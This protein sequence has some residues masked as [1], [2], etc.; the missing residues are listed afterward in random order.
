LLRLHRLE[1]LPRLAQALDAVLVV[2][3]GVGDVRVELLA[4]VLLH[5]PALVVGQLLEVHVERVGPE[6]VV[7]REALLVP[8]LEV[9]DPALHGLPK[10]HDALLALGLV[11][12]DRLVDLL[13]ELAEVLLAG[14]V[15]DPRDAGRREVE[16]LL[17]LLRRHVEQV[18]DPARHALEEPDVRDGGGQVHVAHALTADLRARDLHAAALADDALVADC[19]VLAAVALPVLRGT[20]DALAEEPVLLGLQR[21]VVDCL[22]L[23][24]LAARPR[25]DLRRGREPDL[26]C[27]EIVDVDHVVP[28]SL[29]LA[30]YSSMYSASCS[31]GASSVCPPS[32]SASSVSSDSS[33]ASPSVARTP[34]RSMPSSSAARSRSSSSSRI[35]TPAPSSERTSTSSAS[36]CI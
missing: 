29:G 22:G 1:E 34:D 23:R 33:A 17:A 10:L 7:V 16:D 12:L 28:Q 36:D 24:D 25:A 15:V 9:L 30:P 8:G 31:A 18:A 2:R 19:L 20:E 26:D 21:P 13:L 27:V 32:P 4:Q 11:G 35:S 5:L 3:L 6:Q 14:L